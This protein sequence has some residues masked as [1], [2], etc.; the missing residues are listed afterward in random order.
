VKKIKSLLWGLLGI[1]S[2]LLFV[3]C[4]GTGRVE[5]VSLRLKWLPNANYIAAFVAKENGYFEKYNIDC[6]INPGGQD[7]D[8][9]RLVA[10]GSDD[11]GITGADQLLLGRSKGV[12]IVAIAMEMQESPVCFFTKADAGIITPKDFV[13]KRVGIK[14]G[15]NTETEYRAMLRKQDIEPKS[16]TEVPV[17][18]DLS[19]FLENKVDVWPGYI[20]NEPLT[21]RR[22]GYDI[23]IIRPSEFGVQMYGN[24]IVTTEKMIKENPKLVQRFVNAMLEAWQWTAEHPDSAVAILIKH[25][26]KLDREQERQGLEE[27]LKLVTAGDASTYGIGWMIEE[28]WRASQDIL[29]DEGLLEQPINLDSAFTTRFVKKFRKK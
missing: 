8:A 16:I 19:P 29:V 13:G 25:N 4:P 9:V 12:P 20:S 17:K 28:G 22:K 2:V 10:S 3:S 15:T 21:A 14:H 7:L 26:P 1:L 18:F 5:K 27:T 6:T 11:F 24:L 23:K